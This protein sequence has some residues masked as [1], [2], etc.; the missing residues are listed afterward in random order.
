VAYL[1][2]ALVLYAGSNKEEPELAAFGILHTELG[3]RFVE[4]W[5]PVSKQVLSS[6]RRHHGLL[7]YS[8]KSSGV[9]RFINCANQDANN[10]ET[11]N[12][13]SPYITF[14]R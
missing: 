13:F 2:R 3:V 6:I 10:H 11:H 5:L 14:A 8:A 7:F 12:E 1:S 4:N 9:S